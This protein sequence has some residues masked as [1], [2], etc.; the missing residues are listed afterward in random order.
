[1]SEDTILT[2]DL[3]G[4]W[5]AE[6]DEGEHLRLVREETYAEAQAA[7][8]P[9]PEQVW[10]SEQGGAVQH[11][12]PASQVPKVPE[13][14]EPHPM[15]YDRAQCEKC[16]RR[17]RWVTE[18]VRDDEETAVPLIESFALLDLA[19]LV[20]PDRPPRVWTWDGILPKGEQASLIAPGGAGKS[21]I[22]LALAVALALGRDEFIGRP[23]TFTGRVF[24][25]DMENSEDDWA[26]RLLSLGVTPANV[27]RLC[28]RMVPL[29]MPPLRGL[30]TRVGAAQ[31]MAL[32]ERHGIGSDDLLVLDSTQRVTEGDENSNDTIRRL[33]L[34]TVAELKRRGITTFRTDNTGHEGDRARGASAKRDDVGYSWFLKPDPKDEEVFTLESSKRRA[35][36]RAVKFTFRR[37]EDEQGR[38]RFTEAEGPRLGDVMADA[39]TYLDRLGIDPFLGQNKAWEMVKDLPDRGR[40]LSRTV[41]RAAQSERAVRDGLEPCREGGSR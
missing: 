10:V 6:A 9:A 1:M 33:Y 41:I 16:A 7:G 23:L 15:G 8:G 28:S 27:G 22:L 38:L 5:S 19:A 29:S 4:D 21:L 12:V 31:L 20:A 13:C 17:R 3:A 40:H 36:G 32:L 34:H 26:E 2:L 35:K 39:R 14:D 37:T 30:D 25:V 11:L 18:Q 24:Y